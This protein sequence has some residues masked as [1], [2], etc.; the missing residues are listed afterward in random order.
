MSSARKIANR[1]YNIKQVSPP[2][3]FY[4]FTEDSYYSNYP[5]QR[6]FAQARNHDVKT[7]I[8]ENIR[9]SSEIKKED[10]NL[11]I[12]KSLKCN[13][14]V[15][16]EV[17]RL[18]FFKN[19]IRNSVVADLSKCTNADFIG[20]VIFKINFFENGEIV[21]NVYESVI[22]PSK[23]PNNY[24][25]TKNT[26]ELKICDYKFTI[27]GT[28]YNQ[29]NALTNVCAHATLK[30][31]LSSLKYDTIISH[32]QINE[33]LD[34]DHTNNTNNAGKTKGL[35][36]CQI[37][38]VLGAFQ[39][40]KYGFSETPTKLPKS[41][42]FQRYLYSSIESGQIALLGF[43]L[44]MKKQKN[45][46]A[47]EPCHIVPVIG[48]TFNQDA[49]V[50]NAD[51]S[52]F[53]I[54][55]SISY[56]PSYSWTSSLIIHDDNFGSYYCIPWK[57][58]E[59]E[60]VELFYGIISENIVHDPIEIEP[61]GERMFQ[62]IILEFTKL[63]INAHIWLK[64]LCKYTLANHFVL[65]TLLLDKVTYIKSLKN[66]KDWE[67]NNISKSAIETASELLPDRFWLIEISVPQLYATNKRKLA[68]IFIRNTNYTPKEENID[69]STFIFARVPSFF[70]IYEGLPETKFSFYRNGIE[71]HIPLY[72]EN[73]TN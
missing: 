59:K 51:E 47:K 36:S 40:R 30:T 46:D 49:W 32:E 71:D 38:K 42:I 57:Y 54:G 10:A 5:L 70:V 72:S 25:H 52:Y 45:V 66:S 60:H 35:Q 29:Q 61:I 9:H 58:L 13:N 11:Q 73:I 8:I 55:K 23:Y 24:I 7:I 20:Y 17:H 4:Q 31:L 15:K 12:R 14:F 2:F 53:K 3:R 27:A 63:N 56:F 65:R 69:W 28:L 62:D 64:R 39:L 67:N 22:I 41:L 1:Y 44:R 37:E 43:R 6:I 33:I 16:S 21:S 18:S 34:I 26:Y 48:H 50:P 19:H 68:E